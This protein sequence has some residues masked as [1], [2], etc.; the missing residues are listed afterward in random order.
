[1]KILKISTTSRLAT[2]NTNKQQQMRHK[3]NKNNDI[4]GQKVQQEL[5]PLLILNNNNS[6]PKHWKSLIKVVVQ[7]HDSPTPK[8]LLQSVCECY[9]MRNK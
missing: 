6:G 3:S 4:N 2:T 9:F 5:L 1:L 8:T 7:Q